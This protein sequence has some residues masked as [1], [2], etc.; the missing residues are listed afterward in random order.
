MAKGLSATLMG[1]GV[2]ARGLAQHVHHK[3]WAYLKQTWESVHAKAMGNNTAPI[4]FGQAGALRPTPR[5]IF[6][7]EKLL[8]IVRLIWRLT[9]RP[10]LLD[11]IPTKSLFIARDIEAAM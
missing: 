10:P 2:S 7:K 5:P 3:F 4:Q 6:I 11:I 1:Q 9:I 8:Y